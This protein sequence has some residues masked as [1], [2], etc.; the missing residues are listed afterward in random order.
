[1]SGSVSDMNSISRRSM[2]K[3]A[4]QKF[5]SEAEG[6]GC[7]AATSP[8]LMAEALQKLP[9]GPAPM[10]VISHILAGIERL[11]LIKKIE[12]RGG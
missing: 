10:G 8:K 2:P 9:D 3:S 1:M 4:A 11:G 7:K 6:P 12:M 5:P